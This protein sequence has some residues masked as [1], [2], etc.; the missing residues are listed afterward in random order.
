MYAEQTQIL[1]HHPYQSSWWTWPFDVRPIWYL[2]ERADGAQRGVLLVGN[3]A[4]FWG[5]LVAVAA[6]LYGW[7]RSRSPTLLAAAGLWIGSY[8]IWAIIPKSLGFFYY[9]YLP[10]VLLCVPLAVALDY[11]RRGPKGDRPWDE[12][13]LVLALGLFVLF[14]PVLSAAPLSGPG[15]FRFWTWFPTWV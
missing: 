11:F 10:S 3:P 9:Y 8:L 13:T 6:C 1:P 7:W 2:Y 4:I 14:Y 12:W 5:G 15:A